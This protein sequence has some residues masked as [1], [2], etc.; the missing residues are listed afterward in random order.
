[1]TS[2]P[3]DATSATS[4]GSATAAASSTSGN[5]SGATSLETLGLG[6]SAGIVAGIAYLTWT[7]HGDLYPAQ[8]CLDNFCTELDSPFLELR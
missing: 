2:S 5:T 6:L 1:M 7:L 3:A 4:S 8:I